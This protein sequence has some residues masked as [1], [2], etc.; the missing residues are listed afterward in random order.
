MIMGDEVWWWLIPI[1]PTYKVNYNEHIWSKQEII[2][3][4][5]LASFKEDR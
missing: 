1:Q 4:Y 2:Q 3:M 5:R